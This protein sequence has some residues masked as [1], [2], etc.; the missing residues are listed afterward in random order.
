MLDAGCGTGRVGIELAPAGYPPASH[1]TL[2]QSALTD[3][4]ALPNPRLRL[5]LPAA[6][7]L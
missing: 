5:L 1:G 6:R 3:R 4:Q 2:S 7:H